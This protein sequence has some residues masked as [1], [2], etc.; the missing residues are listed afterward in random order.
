MTTASV[1]ESRSRV[2]KSVDFK[3]VEDEAVLYSSGAKTAKPL[4]NKED[5]AE[6]KAKFE[7]DSPAWNE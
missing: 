7:A 1:A 2:E 3:L 4:G 6:L 5:L